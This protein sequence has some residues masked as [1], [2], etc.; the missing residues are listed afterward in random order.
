MFKLNNNLNLKNYY[1]NDSI[2]N[3]TNNF[4]NC[5]SINQYLH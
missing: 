5:Y 1:F 3:L 2:R 4:Y